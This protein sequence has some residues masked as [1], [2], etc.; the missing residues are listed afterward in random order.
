[1]QNVVN[2]M[3]P[4]GQISNGIEM[5]TPPI[6]VS[7]S[8][9]FFFR[10]FAIYTLLPSFDSSLWYLLTLKWSYCLLTLFAF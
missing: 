4:Y 9:P 2:Q 3:E 7:F 6:D 1:M 10:F 8:S 5:Y